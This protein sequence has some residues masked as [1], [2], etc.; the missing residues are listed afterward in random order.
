MIR[1]WVRIYHKFG[2]DDL[3]P[4]KNWQSI[5]KI[6]RKKFLTKKQKRDCKKLCVKIP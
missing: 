3:I 5:N 6:F 4:K 1:K 2:I